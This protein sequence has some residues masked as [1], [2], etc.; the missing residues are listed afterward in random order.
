MLGSVYVLFS[1]GLTLTW[2]ALNLLNLAHGAIF[3]AGALVA[4][5]L[6]K[7]TDVGL[8]L[9][10]PAAMVACGLIAVVLEWAVYRAIRVRTE[11]PN[12]AELATF[13]AAIAA[14][15][16]PIAVAL[17]I[18]DGVPVAAPESLLHVTSTT[19]LGLQVTN[20]DILICVVALVVSL[21]LTWFIRVTR[22]GRALRALAFDR[23][24]CELLGISA[25]RLA[26]MTMFVSGALAGAAGVLLAVQLNTVDAHMGDALLLKAFA[27]IIL[28]G[29]GSLGG[30]IVAAY[31]LALVETLTFAYVTADLK[32]AVAFALIIVVLLVAPQGI[33]SRSA[34]QRP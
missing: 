5:E 32:N 15:A 12:E 31:L 1:L 9:V 34:W 27:V 30:A 16:I 21:A 29:V 13:M 6:G 11:N 22:H 17:K 18:T 14:A 3:M 10:L 28:A 8:V 26:T 20:S 25:N 4:Y 2:G 24:T 19:I 7:S 33:F 23:G